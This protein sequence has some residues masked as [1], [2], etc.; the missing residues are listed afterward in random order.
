MAGKGYRRWV[1]GGSVGEGLGGVGVMYS[2]LI[3]ALCWTF[4][5]EDLCRGR[6]P[7]TEALEAALRLGLVRR[8]RRARSRSSLVNSVCGEGIFVGETSIGA[9]WILP[10]SSM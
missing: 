7:R 10:V 8:V 1:G 3:R 4:E 9:G 2:W 6:F 5:F